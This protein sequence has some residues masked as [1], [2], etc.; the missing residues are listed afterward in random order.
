MTS[1]WDEYVAGG[2]LGVTGSDSD[3][4]YAGLDSASA[5]AVTTDIAD[6]ILAGQPADAGAVA[7]DA[8]ADTATTADAGAAATDAAA[9]DA[10]AAATDAAATDAGAAATDSAA[11]AAPVVPDAVVAIVEVVL[12]EAAN[13][14]DWAD[15]N[16]ATGDEWAASAG[17]YAQYTEASAAAGFTNAAAH[18]LDDA[19]D[20]AGVAGDHY[21][22]PADHYGAA[23]SDLHAAGPD[24]SG[25]DTSSHGG[26]E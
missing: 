7:T 21:E 23:A 10:G 24:L 19:A 5:S 20:Q 1:S 9:T 2:D 25:Y 4:A 15:W 14:Q 11:D 22:T 8:P 16:A 3:V 17:S 18:A 6:S 12:D 26:S 13:S